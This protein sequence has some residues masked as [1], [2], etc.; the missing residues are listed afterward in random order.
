MGVCERCGDGA[1]VVAPR[2]D[3]SLSGAV[4]EQQ[5]S[6]CNGDSVSDLERDAT[7]G[8]HG[9][10]DAAPRSSVCLFCQEDAVGV[11][12]VPM[13]LAAEMAASTSS[14]SGRSRVRNGS[15]DAHDDVSIPLVMSEANSSAAQSMLL[16]QQRRREATRCRAVCSGPGVPLDY[17]ASLEGHRGCRQCWERWEQQQVQSAAAN[18]DNVDDCVRCPICDLRVDI[19]RAY[20]TVLCKPCQRNVVAKGDAKV[21]GLLLVAKMKGFCWRSRQLIGLS[22]LCGFFG[23]QALISLLAWSI[24]GFQLEK[25]LDG[26]QMHLAGMPSTNTSDYETVSIA[27]VQSSNGSRQTVTMTVVEH[28]KRHHDLADLGSGFAAAIFS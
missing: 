23:A 20:D 1:D 2:H 26:G 21:K 9:Q 11:A 8:V 7:L 24:C 5:P 14:S 25:F 22:M 28:P 15:D 17:A 3:M 19:R 18:G 12:Y 4:D 6:L 27:R 16:T 13:H 10:H